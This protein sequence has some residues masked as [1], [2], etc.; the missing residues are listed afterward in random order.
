M[1]E[2][3]IG[4][5]VIGEDYPTFVIAEAG[6]NHDCILERG[7]Q[8]IIM[9]AENGAD[10]IKFQTFK[11]D[12]LV[13][14]TVPR[15]WEQNKPGTTQI[16]LYETQDD[17]TKD[18][19]LELVDTCKK[20]NIIFLSTPFDEDSVDFLEELNVPAYKIAS[21]D[22]TNVPF[23]RYIAKKGKPIILSLGM[24]SIGEIEEAVSAIRREGNDDIILL[25]CMVIYPTP[26]EQA[27]VRFIQTLQKL[28][29]DYPVGFSD[30]TLGINVPIVASALGAKIIEKHFTIDKNIKGAPDHPISIDPDELKEM[31]NG[32]REAQLCLGSETRKITG[33]EIYAMQSGRRRIVAN[34]NIPA[35]TKIEPYMISMKRST[36]GLYPRYYDVIIGKEARVD[37]KEDEGITWNKI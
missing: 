6:C 19:Y 27:N 2:I 25:H 34:I 16:S 10:A 18:E 11:A 22:L 32:I 4:N 28:F 30:H 23:L 9:A 21:T 36:E 17:L 33:E 3:K 1:K 24:G 35:G 31:V 14:K 15:F 26:A 29:P 37:I 7:K 13:T 8:L 20:K 5:K 12:K